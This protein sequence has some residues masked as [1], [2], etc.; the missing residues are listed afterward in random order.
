MSLG[1]RI[2]ALRTARGWSQ[3]QLAEALEVSRQ[4]VSKWETDGSVPDLDKLVKLCRIFD[5]TLDQ[6]VQGREPVPEVP[7]QASGDPERAVTPPSPSSPMDWRRSRTAPALVLLGIGVLFLAALFVL[8]TGWLALWL[9]L[10]WLASA[11]IAV[12][13][14]RHPVLWSVWA[15]HFGAASLFYFSTTISWTLVLDTL[16]FDPSN[17]YTRL[18]LAW[19]VVIVRAV[20]FLVT[21]RILSRE[22]KAPSRRTL[23]LCGVLALVL[24]VTPEP[25]WYLLRQW[26]P[27]WEVWRLREGWEYPY[28][29][30]RCT[31]EWLRLLGCTLCAGIA[32]RKGQNP[33]K[34]QDNN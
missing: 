25:F 29:L 28:R 16:H 4:A 14:R 18:A 1:E 21:A 15:I 22:G 20:L 30:I 33:V 34:A 8:G 6:L 32:L 27:Q 13:S 31:V 12:T 9:A 3:N 11:L 7:F 2:C 17:N 19:L 5:V 10:P 24:L 26:D 23:V